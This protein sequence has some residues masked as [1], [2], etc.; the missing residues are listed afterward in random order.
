MPKHILK[1]HI[2]NS[3]T[4]ET[5]VNT[6]GNIIGTESFPALPF[7]KAIR[8]ITDCSLKDAK[9][10][11]DNFQRELR[12]LEENSMDRMVKEIEEDL[13]YFT[14][15]QLQE[16]RIQTYKIRMVNREHKQLLY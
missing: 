14:K 15:Q 8:M 10:F 3:E 4:G 16:L 6:S 1:F 9:E 13:G 2:I 7:I 5:E 12:N 11:S